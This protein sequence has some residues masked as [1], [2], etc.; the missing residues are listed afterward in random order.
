MQEQDLLSALRM[1]FSISIFVA[2]QPAASFPSSLYQSAAGTTNLRIGQCRNQPLDGTQ[3]DLLTR[4]CKDDDFAGRGQDSG[5][6]RRR[7]TVSLLQSNYTDPTLIESR[8]IFAVSSVEPSETPTTSV[9]ALP[10]PKSARF[11]SF[12]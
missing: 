4:I 6:E 8:A 10:K 12:A 5:I 7:F 2:S 11:A 3:L 1:Q 9:C